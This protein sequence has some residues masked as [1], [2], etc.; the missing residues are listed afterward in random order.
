MQSHELVC[1]IVPCS[2]IFLCLSS[3]QELYSAVLVIAKLG[4]PYLPSVSPSLP[5]MLEDSLD[6]RVEEAVWESH[7][8][9]LG[10]E[11]HRPH[12]NKHQIDEGA[13]VGRSDD[14]D[15]V[16]DAEQWND[17]KEGLSGSPILK[18]H[19]FKNKTKYFRLRR[20]DEVWF[21]L[22]LWLLSECS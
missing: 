3:S 2:S 15:E 1:S 16:G 20:Y 21:P 9:A 18:R 5:V 17:D 8:E 19:F 4:K 7:G 10:G 11:E 14:G 22:S 13:L 12:V 6:L